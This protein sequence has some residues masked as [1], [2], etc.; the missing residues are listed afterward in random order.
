MVNFFQKP[1]LLCSG[2]LGL[3]NQLISILSFWLLQHPLCQCLFD[4]HLLMVENPRDSL[5]SLLFCRSLDNGISCHRFRD[6]L[7]QSNLLACLCLPLCAP[8][9]LSQSSPSSHPGPPFCLLAVQAV[10][11]GTPFRSFQ[12][13]C[14]G[15]SLSLLKL[16]SFLSLDLI[17]SRSYSL[18]CWGSSSPGWQVPLYASSRRVATSLHLRGSMP[19]SSLSIWSLASF[20][21]LAFPRTNLTPLC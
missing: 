12:A 20:S 18:Q 6:H 9:W 10:D 8:P 7:C 13:L 1:P 3:V 19:R 14:C 11:S 17:F 4:Q 16:K 2:L 21:H 5:I 15:L